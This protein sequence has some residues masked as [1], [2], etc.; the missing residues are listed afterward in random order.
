[1]IDP[2]ALSQRTVHAVDLIAKQIHAQDGTVEES[3]ATKLAA[4]VLA[5]S[6]IKLS[7]AKTKDGETAKKTGYLLFLSNMQAE[8]LADIALATRA[9]GAAL[10]KKA[11]KA[12][13]A[14]PAQ[15]G[16]DLA[17]F[18]RMVADAPDLNVDASVQVAHALGVHKLTPEFDYFTAVDD[19]SPEDNAGAGMI[20]TVEFN[21]ST[22]YRYATINVPLLFKNLGDKT[23]T[24]QAVEAF[25]EAFITSMPTG[26]QNTFANRTL[27]HAAVV[28]VRD[29]QPV[30]LVG[31]FETPVPSSA[32]D[33]YIKPA[34]QKFIDYAAQIDEAYGV[35]PLSTFVLRI[36]GDATAPLA[37]L[38]EPMPLNQLVESAGGA[39]RNWLSRTD[40]TQA[41]GVAS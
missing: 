4:D 23:A 21:S 31:A 33:G 35:E 25:T 9:S 2:S 22:V 26:K 1:L 7:D 17:L 19:C 41:A 24:I 20:G 14:A 3:E 8:K 28:Q 12:I 15:T 16:I 40:S 11:V 37:P 29:R 38:G 6:G 5:A 18:G 27:P 39:V 36:D 13:L 10:D 34:C 30:N 32:E